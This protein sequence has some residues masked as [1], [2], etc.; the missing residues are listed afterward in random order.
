LDIFAYDNFAQFPTSF[1]LNLELDALHTSFSSGANPMAFEFTA[2]Y[3]ADV[4][5]HRLERFL[6]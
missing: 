1:F 5:V 4:E 2:I 6:G 3:N